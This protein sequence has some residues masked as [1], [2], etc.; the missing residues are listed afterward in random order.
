MKVNNLN[1]TNIVTELKTA[2]L[3]VIIFFYSDLSGPCRMVLP[4]IEQI[5]SERRD[6]ILFKINV[7][8]NKKASAEYNIEKV[9]TIVSFINGTE[10]RRRVGYSGKKEI[11]ALID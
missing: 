9:P 1:A 7:D 10:L 6:L 5:A 11:L 2:T 8:G 4:I 3:P